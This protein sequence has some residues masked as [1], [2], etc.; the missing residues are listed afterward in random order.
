MQNA[1]SLRPL[2]HRSGGILTVT[3]NTSGTVPQAL[4]VAIAK[5]ITQGSSVSVATMK[6]AKEPTL[7]AHKSSHLAQFCGRALHRSRPVQCCYFLLC[8]GLMTAPHRPGGLREI[9]H[10]T[11]SASEARWYKHHINAV[12]VS[13]V[14]SISSFVLCLL[15]EKRTGT[16][17]AAV[18]KAAITCEPWAAP[19]LQALPPE[20]QI[21]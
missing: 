14:W 17:S 12:S 11:F 21:L 9:K 5:V 19:L 13:I 10:K 16:R 20:T 8:C 1:V 15:N 6:I 2:M 18:S 3:K 4:S 7:N